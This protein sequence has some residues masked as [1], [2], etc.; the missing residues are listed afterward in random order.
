MD[1]CLIFAPSKG[2][3]EP[4]ILPYSIRQ[5]CL[6]GAGAGQFSKPI[7]HLIYNHSH[8]DHASG[9]Q[10]F[11]D[12]TVIAHENAPAAIDGVAVDT[13]IN[14]PTEVTVGGKTLELVP[15]GLGHGENMLVMIVRPEDVAFVVD[16]V[17]PDRVPYQDLAAVDV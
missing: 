1:F 8:G 4:E 15:L 5:I 10:V 6:I 2:Y 7:T 11:G 13:R 17:S 16:V 9:G 3:D 14:K 12:L